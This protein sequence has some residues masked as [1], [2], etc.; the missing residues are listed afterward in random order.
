MYVQHIDNG[1][2]KTHTVNDLREAI[3]KMH[4]LA[5]GIIYIYTEKKGEPI[6]LFNYVRMNP[7][8]DEGVWACFVKPKV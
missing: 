1:K 6:L 3:D 8:D 7:L 5:E 2:T 4:T